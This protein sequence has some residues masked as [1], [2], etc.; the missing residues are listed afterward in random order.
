MTELEQK[1]IIDTIDQEGPT[2]LMD[3]WAKYPA[4]GHIYFTRFVGAFRRLREDRKIV[5]VRYVNN[6]T[7]FFDFIGFPVGAKIMD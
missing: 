4:S 1:F 7:G 6:K 3:L 5:V 2:N